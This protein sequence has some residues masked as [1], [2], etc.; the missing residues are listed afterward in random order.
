M[1]Y[2]GLKS[3]S[4]WRPKRWRP[5]RPAKFREIARP[6]RQVARRV[7]MVAQVL[8]PFL[9]DAKQS[10]EN[11]DAPIVLRWQEMDAKVVDVEWKSLFALLRFIKGKQGNS[12]VVQS[13]L[14][15]RNA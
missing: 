7:V 2:T 10:Q 14:A 13:I 11:A 8:C 9:V 3:Q 1:I 15:K 4:H 5:L 12:S 6:P